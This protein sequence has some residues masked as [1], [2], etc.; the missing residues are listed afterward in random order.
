MCSC[1][2]T[3]NRN[4]PML[5]NMIQDAVLC[6]TCSLVLF[7]NSWLGG[8]WSIYWVWV[9]TLLHVLLTLSEVQ[10]CGF[11]LPCIAL[12]Q[13][14]CLYDGQTGMRAISN[15]QTSTTTGWT[16]LLFRQLKITISKQ[17]MLYYKA[18]IQLQ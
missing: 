5:V 3:T 18:N 7:V 12:Y 16:V 4:I 10:M 13:L 17:I 9:D 8:N 2:L 14:F 11:V 6:T 15:S 1:N